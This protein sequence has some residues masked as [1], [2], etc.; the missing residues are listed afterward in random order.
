MRV[1]PNYPLSEMLAKLDEWAKEAGEGVE[2][3]DGP[4]YQVI[5]CLFVYDFLLGCGN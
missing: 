1:T 2:W 4:T 3:A 5:F